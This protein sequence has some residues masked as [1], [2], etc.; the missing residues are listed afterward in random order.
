[1]NEPNT[2]VEKEIQGKEN[3]RI[4]AANPQKKSGGKG[5]GSVSPATAA[6]TG[7]SASGVVIGL[8]LLISLVALG[9]AAYGLFSVRQLQSDNQIR[10]LADKSLAMER[11]LGQFDKKLNEV[12]ATAQSQQAEQQAVADRVDQRLDQIDRTLVELKSTAGLKSRDWQI[13]EVEYLLRLANQRILV[14]REVDGAVGLLG[15]ADNILREAEGISAHSVRQ[16]IAADLARLQSVVKVD[17]DGVFLKIGAQIDLVDQLKQK[18]LS[19]ELIAAHDNTPAVIR[20]DDTQ[21]G[22]LDRIENFAQ[23]VAVK[24]G[25]LVDYRRGNERVDPI[26]PPEEEYYLRQNLTLKLEQTQ[27]ALLKGNQT[28]FQYGLADSI[29]WVSK[30]FD[31]DDL[32]TKAMLGTLGELKSIEVAQRLPDISG[33]LLQARQLL[34]ELHTQAA[35]SGDNPATVP[36]K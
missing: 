1:M 12:A 35:A 19:F 36:N 7:S 8:A 30:Y 16:A 2:P 11:G 32:T 24:L 29:K 33:S 5:A 31:P 26:L 27:I 23:R 6:S 20:S 14:E 10:M 3:T 28:A 4:A 9:A 15:A 18:R 22:W 25:Q 21:S 17:V 34:S 13:A